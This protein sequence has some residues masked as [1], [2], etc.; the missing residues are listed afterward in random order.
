MAETETAIVELVRQRLADGRRVSDSDVAALVA[1]IDRLNKIDAI[2]LKSCPFCGT[3]AQMG[4]CQ[5]DASVR[6]GKKFFWVE[7]VA[8]VCPMRRVDGSEIA[9]IETD[10][11]DTPAE[12]AA[13]WNTR[14]GHEA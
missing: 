11:F 10:Y 13:A 12:A 8:P 2:E 5:G 14:H 3:S 7:H 6:G 1:E 9:G 4:E